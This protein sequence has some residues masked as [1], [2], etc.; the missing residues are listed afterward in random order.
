[1]ESEFFCRE[2]SGNSLK[3]RK[4]LSESIAQTKHDRRLF[5]DGLRAIGGVEQVAD[6][7]ANFILISLAS[8]QVAAGLTRSLLSSENVFVKDISAKFQSSKGFLRFAVRTAAENARL[9]VAI[10]RLL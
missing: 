6:S 10:N 7:H 4:T 5:A 3:H 1:M 9:C 2:F 8:K